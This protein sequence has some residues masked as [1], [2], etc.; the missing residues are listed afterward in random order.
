LQ[1]GGIQ[2]SPK[3]SRMMGL[4]NVFAIGSR[5]IAQSA[6]A[7]GRFLTPDHVTFLSQ[8]DHQLGLTRNRVSHG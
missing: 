5:E 1:S 6:S 2:L 7:L 3:I 8:H 4:H